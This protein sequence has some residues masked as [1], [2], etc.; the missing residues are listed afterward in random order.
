MY[1]TPLNKNHKIFR[2]FLY[3]REN[4]MTYEKTFYWTN[5]RSLKNDNFF[6]LKYVRVDGD[7]IYQGWF[8]ESTKFDRWVD[9]KRA[10]K[11]CISSDQ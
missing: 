11:H 9:S 10:I 7:Q 5:D 3:E 8:I 6:L 4:G 2:I 1:T